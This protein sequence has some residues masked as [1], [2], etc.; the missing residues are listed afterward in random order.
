MLFEKYSDF[1]YAGKGSHSVHSALQ[2]EV[3]NH[4][5][6]TQKPYGIHICQAFHLYLV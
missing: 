2:E 6:D 4:N 1:F 5:H 3:W